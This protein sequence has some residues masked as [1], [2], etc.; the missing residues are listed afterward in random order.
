MFCTLHNKSDLIR[1][2]FSTMQSNEASNIP[3]EY[4]PRTTGGKNNRNNGKSKIVLALF[5]NTKS[6]AAASFISSQQLRQAVRNHGRPRNDQVIAIFCFSE[7][8]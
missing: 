7:L 5:Q 1:L 6:N 8:Y 3:S 4:A 2:F